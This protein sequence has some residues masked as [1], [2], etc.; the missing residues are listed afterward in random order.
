[1]T[2]YS[3]SLNEQIEIMPGFYTGIQ[4]TLEQR[5]EN[6]IMRRDHLLL[7]LSDW[8]SI[9]MKCEE[10]KEYADDARE[11]ATHLELKTIALETCEMLKARVAGSRD[12]IKRL[13]RELIHLY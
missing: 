10:P 4:G 13:E 11:E 8:L 1:M 7:Y 3:A 5:L 12:E 6:E 2:N 9:L